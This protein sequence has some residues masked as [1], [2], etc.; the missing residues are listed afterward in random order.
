MRRQLNAAKHAN[1]VT[2]H[3]IKL[4][5][6]VRCQALIEKILAAA[7][8]QIPVL[9][10]EGSTGD[11]NAPYRWVIDPIDGTNNFAHKIMNFCVSIAAIQ[12]GGTIAE[13]GRSVPTNRLGKKLVIR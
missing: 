13:S 3:D 12:N 11:V 4:E 1:L 2:Q 5:L 10:E 8:P 7:F 6:D 9:G